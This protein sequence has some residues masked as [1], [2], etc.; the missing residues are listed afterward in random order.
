MAERTQENTAT[1]STPA[2]SK[3]GNAGGTPVNAPP[4]PAAEKPIA[5]VGN[6]GGSA[7]AA[8]DAA[9]GKLAGDAKDQEIAELKGRLERA[10]A[11]NAGVASR[12]SAEEKARLGAEARRSEADRQSGVDR[13]KM[14]VAVN[15]STGFMGR[16]SIV[17]Q[18]FGN[19]AGEVLFGGIPAHKIDKWSDGEI[20][21][22]LA[23]N[24]RP[25]E[26][27]VK[28]KNGPAQSGTTDFGIVTVPANLPEGN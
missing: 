21:G 17:G 10:E 27:I 19:E 7:D 23:E 12:G 2:D 4:N 8:F 22:Q 1:P 28:P 15:A 16:F 13:S 9:K 26:Y 25:G 24:S 5:V 14:R 3:G 6:P 11:A 18:G 20:D